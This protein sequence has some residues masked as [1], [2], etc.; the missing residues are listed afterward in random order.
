VIGSTAALALE[1]WPQ[2]LPQPRAVPPVSVAFQWAPCCKTE[3]A[4]PTQRELSIGCCAGDFG[5]VRL[6]LNQRVLLPVLEQLERIARDTRWREVAVGE[7]ARLGVD[8]S[9]PA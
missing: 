7:T 3:W 6:A 1:A 4:K 5:C 2:P 9:M 8:A